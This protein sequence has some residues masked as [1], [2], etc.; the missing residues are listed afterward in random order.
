MENK[1]CVSDL[2]ENIKNNEEIDENVFYQI[3]QLNEYIFYLYSV[4]VKE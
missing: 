4:N 3:A 2:I 1:D